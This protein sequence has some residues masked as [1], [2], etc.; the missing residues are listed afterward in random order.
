[1]LVNCDIGERGAKHP[2]DIEL[3]QYIDIANIACGG[4][5]GNE[6]SIH[7][8][9][10]L[11]L[12]N[13]IHITAHLSYPDKENFGRVSMQLPL[14]QLY[15]S[16][17]KQLAFMPQVKSVKLHGALYND[18]CKDSLLAFQVT[19]WLKKNKIESVITMP[20]N[21]LAHECEKLNIQILNESFA[22]RRYYKNSD[23]KLLLVPRT[24]P[25]ASIHTLEEALKQCSTITKEHCI[26]LIENIESKILNYQKH[27]L[28]ADT[29]CIHS[30]SKI[31][32]KLAKE[33]K[34]I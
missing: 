34:K 32:L 13:N 17:N 11:A 6:E 30:D 9:Y 15:E 26:Y 16:L 19:Q 12:K 7:R 28:R 27:A 23:G 21:C 18:S 20:D 31:A 22:E 3:M 24:K 4:H 29:I 2:V 25:F 8:F 33:I 5:A 1:M 14:E 10:E